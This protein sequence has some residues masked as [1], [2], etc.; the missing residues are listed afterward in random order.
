L[1]LASGHLGA[2]EL[3]AGAGQVTIGSDAFPVLANP[4]TAM[5]QMTVVGGGIN[6]YPS[7]GVALLISYGHQVFGAASGGLTR[8]NEETLVTRLQLV[9]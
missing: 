1:D 5:K 2:V 3:V 4:N 7:R 8:P 9:L 6:W